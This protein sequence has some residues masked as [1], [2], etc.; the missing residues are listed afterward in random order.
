MSW[1]RKFEI[2]D[3]LSKSSS[4]S[5]PVAQSSGLVGFGEACPL[6]EGTVTGIACSPGFDAGGTCWDGLVVGYPSLAV[7]L[8]TAG[9]AGTALG[10]AL[11]TRTACGME[12][13]VVVLPVA[14]TTVGPWDTWTTPIV[15]WPIVYVNKLFYDKFE[16]RKTC[17]CKISTLFVVLGVNLTNPRLNFKQF[18]YLNYSLPALQWS[19]MS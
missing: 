10:L 1:I 5:P 4:E 3:S 18:S 14:G 15:G 19:G 7:G 9:T 6:V 2:P 16:Q 8:P 12:V 13:T 11:E 17:F